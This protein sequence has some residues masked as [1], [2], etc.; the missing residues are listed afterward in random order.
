[1]YMLFLFLFMC[2]MGLFFPKNTDSLDTS[3]F[4]A[5]KPAW[6]LALLVSKKLSSF[7]NPVQFQDDKH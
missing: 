4:S 3:V 2:L 5:R 6:I 1:M 7:F